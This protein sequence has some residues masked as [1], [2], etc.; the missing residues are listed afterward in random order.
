MS[1]PRAQYNAPSMRRRLFTVL[2]ALSLLLCA[3]TCVLWVR[4]YFREDGAY[5]D[6]GDVG[7]SDY[8][9]C[10]QSASGGL[11]FRCASRATRPLLSGYGRVHWRPNYIDWI[12]GKYVWLWTEWGKQPLWLA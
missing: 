11:M 12:N 8:T 5:V 1:G 7:R 6:R 2:S 10:L 9:F 4:S 3:A